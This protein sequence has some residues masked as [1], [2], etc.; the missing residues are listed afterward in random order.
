MSIV[1]GTA[2]H[3]DHGKTSLVKALT[4]V[5]CD[6]LEEE[7][8]R[9]I[10]IE[11]GFAAL[12]IDK[13]TVIGIV[14][15]PGHEKFV[16]NMVAGASG[17]DAVMLVIAADESVMPQ[18]KEHIEICNLLGIKH[19]LVA[20]TKIDSVDEEM[21]ELAK[22]EVAE[23]LIGSCLEN[24]PIFPV[25]S[26]KNIGL[27]ALK[28]HI[29]ALN[30]DLTKEQKTDLFRLPVDRVFTMKGHG[31]VI[32][33]TS[34]AGK[35]Q[36]SDDLTIYPKNEVQAR[37]RAIQSH[38]ESKEEIQAGKRISINLANCSLDDIER[39]DVLAKPNSLFPCDKW[40]VKLHCLESSPQA[41]S[42]RKEV[43]FHHGAKELPAKVYLFD[44]QVLEKNDTALAEIRYTLPKNNENL[45]PTPLVGVFGD[46]CVLRSSSPL[47]TIAGATLLLPLPYSWTRKD[48][49]PEL[50]EKLMKLEEY[51]ENDPQQFLLAHID[52]SEKQGRNFNE[53]HVLTALNSKQMEKVLLTLSGKGDILCYNKETKAYITKAI[54]HRLE[55]ECVKILEDYHKK[56]PLKQ[57]MLKNMLLGTKNFLLDESAEQ[58]KLGH[59]VLDRLLKSNSI[60]YTNDMYH[61]PNFKVSLQHDE[62]ETQKKILAIL[63]RDVK[64]PP[65][66][67]EVLEEI[68]ISPK[69]AQPLLKML[70]DNKKIT[71]LTDNM[72]YD[73]QTIKMYEEK[74]IE[75]FKTHETLDPA[76]FKEI[77]DG[78]SRKYIIAILEYFDVQKLTLRVGDVRKLR[79]SLT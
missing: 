44:R 77:T 14:D 22:E 38:G 39:G 65:N 15:V 17:I 27:E 78:L 7:K 47:R 31:T 66:I 4:G 55:K 46:R 13:D 60:A 56:E 79:K 71:K 30:K 73:K 62:A 70:V 64:N 61:L 24:A 58:Q 76:A 52:L 19:G 8:K 12:P 34:I 53:L 69:Q 32:T 11:L 42:H 67:K 72:Y 63:Q 75:F 36:L 26:I 29:K 21:L 59:F 25:S 41:I 35:A 16:K 43:H 40:L 23:F 37:I 49:T 33:G 54:Y 6:R 57:G 28:E 74:T 1:I 9:G 51:S 18:T 2:G 48:F 20:L 10:T 50:Q 3:I 5:D 45:V 68:D